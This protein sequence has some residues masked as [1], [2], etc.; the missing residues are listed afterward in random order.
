MSRREFLTTEMTPRAWRMIAYSCVGLCV[1][2]LVFLMEAAQNF[3]M[4]RIDRQLQEVSRLESL[5]DEPFPATVRTSSP[6]AAVSAEPPT[7]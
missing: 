2:G 3:Q 1:Y 4:N 7:E 6:T 5:G